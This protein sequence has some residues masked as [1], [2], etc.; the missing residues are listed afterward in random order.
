MFIERQG[1][2]PALV[3][4]HGWSM[5][6]AV[7]HKLA[8]GLS[9]QYSL[10]LVDLPGHGRSDWQPGALDLDALLSALAVALPTQANWLG[11]SLGGLIAIAFADLYP[12]R[13]NKLSLIA[14]TPRFVQG[15]DWSC[16]MPRSVFENFA[17][18]L[19]ENQNQTLQRFLM[20]QARG[21]EQS[22][23]TIRMLAEE[24][25]TQH[26]PQA[27]ALHAGLDLLL[28]V[29]MRKQMLDL[30]CPIQV[31][32]G[33]R[34]TLIPEIMLMTLRQLKPGIRTDLIPGAG[35]APF[36]SHPVLC[37]QAIEQF[38]NE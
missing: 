16:A 27:A 17:A 5:N 6:S 1:Q 37:Q 12:E 38:I 18:N 14:A 22:R 35:H 3:M 25:A 2:G 10:Y 33:Q 34:D 7:W 9:Q 29:D 21:A 26:T 11:W 8:D 15:D 23:D 4:L 36:I 30:R 20:L 31:I 19:D 28:N 32:L 24:L 13:V